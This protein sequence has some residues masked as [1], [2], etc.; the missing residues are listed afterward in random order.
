M[1]ASCAAPKPLLSRGAEKRA[2]AA[3][4]RTAAD[5]VSAPKVTE[6]VLAEYAPRAQ[7]TAS[8]D[9]ARSSLR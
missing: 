6:R 3:L 4:A 7:T 2:T 9:L 8:Q 1:M 5:T